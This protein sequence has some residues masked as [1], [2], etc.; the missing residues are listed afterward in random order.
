MRS[1]FDDVYIIE[2]IG[3]A[4]VFLLGNK[5]EFHLIDSGIFKMTH[6][7]IQQIEEAGFDLKNLKTMILTHCHCDHI[8]GAAEHVNISGARVAAHTGDIPFILQESVIDGPYHGM[9]VEEQKYMKQFGCNIKHVDIA[10]KRRRNVKHIKR[11]ESNMCSGAHS[12]K[13]RAL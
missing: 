3:S 1:I 12:G 2:G 11:A 9:M 8:G 7:L 6:K 5:R 13:H 4:N 10:L